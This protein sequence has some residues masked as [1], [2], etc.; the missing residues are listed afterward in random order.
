MYLGY[1]KNI[2][3]S[4]EHDDYQSLAAKLQNFL[5]CIEMFIAAIAHHYS[6]PHEPFHHN[7]PNYGTHTTWYNGL[8]AMLDI[9]D[10]Q[11][12]VT[13]H[14][15]V[16]GSSLSRR[17]RGRTMYQMPRGGET[18]YLI[19]TPN[20]G[21]AGGN[22]CYQSGI[23]YVGNIKSI[24]NTNRY[25]STMV[26]QQQQQQQQQISSN[27][28]G[29]NII[30]QQRRKEYS[31]KHGLPPKS[32]HQNLFTFNNSNNNHSASTTT[33]ST[34]TTTPSKLLNLSNDIDLVTASTSNS[35]LS[36]QTTSTSSN[37]VGGTGKNV[38]IKKSTSQD[39]YWLSS[40]TDDDIL[41][42]DVKGI[43]NDRINYRD[44]KM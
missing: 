30:Q 34:I 43:E 19:Q 35:S 13:E 44:P 25:G 5:I 9:S 11:Q 27:H 31:P 20:L 18:D 38:H 23:N 6:F 2:F 32:K 24:S 10:I 3:G 7:I 16:V 4:D 1:F 36:N 15:G 28:D 33:H 39:S 26:D 40:P 42:I 12:D 29:I 21:D 37:G 8:L 22:N 17:L 41:G 14:I